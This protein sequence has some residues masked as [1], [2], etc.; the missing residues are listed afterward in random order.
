MVYLEVYILREKP[1]QKI[2]LEGHDIK[3]NYWGLRSE[4]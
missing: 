4:R 3:L 1:Q 2:G